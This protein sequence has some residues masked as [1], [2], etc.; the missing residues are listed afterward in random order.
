[1]MDCFFCMFIPEAVKS[2]RRK[3][4]EGRFWRNILAM[5]VLCVSKLYK[6]HVVL[7]SAAG[8]C[9]QRCFMDRVCMTLLKNTFL[10]DVEKSFLGTAREVKGGLM[11]YCG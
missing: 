5:Y 2:C 4:A 1:M 11:R 8:S 10:M 9:W 7:S 3:I 6:D